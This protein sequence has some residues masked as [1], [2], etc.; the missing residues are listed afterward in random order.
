MRL[1]PVEV[2]KLVVGVII[3]FA[4]LLTL[5]PQSDSAKQIN[6]LFVYAENNNYFMVGCS[7]AAVGCM[8]NL[9]SPSLK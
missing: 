2:L 8:I 5:P 3:I 4:E 7:V 1:E 9:S 6:I